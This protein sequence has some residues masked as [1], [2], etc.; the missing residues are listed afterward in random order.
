MDAGNVYTYR[1]ASL[2]TV[3]TKKRVVAHRRNKRSA[4]WRTEET[5]LARKR[6]A[7]PVRT[8]RREI[9]QGALQRQ[10]EFG[11]RLVVS[12]CVSLSFALVCQKNT[13]RGI[14]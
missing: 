1:R 14:V 12:V 9:P 4:W 5:K 2:V 3:Q 8:S 7:S 13:P 6:E 11:I 10:S